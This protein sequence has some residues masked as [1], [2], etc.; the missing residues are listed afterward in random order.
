V[1]RAVLDRPATTAGNGGVRAR[2]A[3]VRWAVRLYRREWR[4]QL[5][6][7]AL[8]VV[9]V[10]ASVGF[11]TAAYNVAPVAG[12]AEFGSARQLLD[13]DNDDPSVVGA[14]LAAARE[15]FGTVD[16]ITRRSVPVPGAF[17]PF[18]YRGQDPSGPYGG[19]LLSLVDG[20]FPAGADEV[21]LT[22]G[23]AESFGV[24]IGATFAVDG[25]PRT[26]VGLVENPSD[27]GDEFA[28]VSPAHEPSATSATVLLAGDQGRMESF[29]P[30]SG[31]RKVGIRGDV[32][33][34]AL[35]AVGVLAVASVALLL[36][37]LIAGAGFVVIAQRR[38]RQL[39]MLAAVGATQRHLRLALVANGAAVGVV[40]AI[41]GSAA[42]LLGWAVAVP[43]LETELGYRIDRFDVPWWLVA[44]GMALAVV[45]ATAAAFWP[46]RITARTSIVN[47]LSGRPSPPRAVHRSAR[48]A[49]ALLA[50][51]VGCL[52]VAGD[53]ADERSVY[54]SNLLLTGAGTLACGV[55][56]LLVSPLALRA[57]SAG[58]GR[59][60]FTT[61]LALRDL[62]R[63][64]AR[65]GAALA[66]IA[67]VLGIPVAIIV[68]AGGAKHGPDSGNLAERHL[69]VRAGIADGP[70]LPQA[71]DLERLR[72]GVDQV[73]T[74]LGDTTVTA[75]QVVRDPSMPELPGEE[76]RAGVALGVRSGDG[77][78]DL[79]LLYVAT[80]V[81]L[82]LHGLEAAAV[83]R[84]GIATTES[85]DVRIVGLSKFAAGDRRNPEAVSG[86]V[87]FAKRYTSLPSSFITPDAARS[88][89]WEVVE[90]G[91]WLIET[92]RRPTA[93]QLTDARNAA[94]AA[95]LT[96][97]SRDRQGGVAALR[98]RA[99]LAG[100][101][102]ALVVIGMTVGLVRSEVAADVR[103]LTATGA[104]SRTRRALTAATAGVLAT[105][106]V[107][108]G[109][110]GTLLI[111]AVG[112]GPELL[113]RLRWD[114][115]LSLALLAF[116]TP[117]AA[118]VSGWLLG[119]REPPV[120]ARRL[121]A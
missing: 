43:R 87:R 11:A 95:G 73:A 5:L 52:S 29:R 114:S 106:G 1:T 59:L 75:F 58:A 44:A 6:V 51:G 25:T 46:A 91:R 36:V 107:V 103:T 66:A 19:P 69:M 12:N 33:E 68:V 61:R 88:R 37:A 99:A 76:A 86:A 39:G 45:T 54:W 110:V 105:L 49:G 120:L 117:V 23:A 113:T 17:E 70:F 112:Y 74:A 108:I 118:A 100:V 42:A 92:A 40:A 48:L 9:A 101:L 79:S 7:L 60:P 77:W 78:R 81:A 62:A 121:T 53:V 10:A 83:D 115:L 109:A 3:V 104:T 15:W 28:L 98:T 90:A 16:V 71:E 111:V 32:N 63:Y 72:A 119:G 2:R 47:A 94:A 97:E 4:Q 34:A 13:I 27:L 41:V 14:D 50:A 96:I 102:L 89:G 67:L 85:G 55:G 82:A 31:G 35:A 26:V 116:G 80:P 64:Q 93:D 8:L 30:P 21:A 24:R 84:A 56:V 65:S 20:A 57:T 22:D 38:L 18:E